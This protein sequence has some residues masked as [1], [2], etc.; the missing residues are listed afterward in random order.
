MTTASGAPALA[1]SPSAGDVGQLASLD[2]EAIGRNAVAA[3]LPTLRPYV[4][5]TPVVFLDREELGLAPGPL[6]LKL[7]HLQHSGSFKA[8]GAFA[9]LLTHRVP[10]AGIVAASG[11]NH[12]S[13]VAYAASRLQ[14][15]ATIF[16]PEVSSPAK[17]SRIESYGATLV[18]GG[19]DY[20]AARSA[21]ADF[22]ARTGAFDV[23][24]FDAVATILGAGSIALELQDQAPATATVLASVGGG[25]LLAGLCA[26]YAAQGAGANGTGGVRVVGVEPK[27][28]P[29]LT[30][31][32]GAGHPA[33]AP[34]GSIAIDSLAPR[35]LGAHTY[36]VIAR[37]GS[38]SVLVDDADISATQQ[39]LWDRLRLVV[40][41][42][43]C[44]SL[45]ALV[46]GCY[47]PAPNETVAVVLSGANTTAVDF[48]R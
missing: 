8:R 9:N 42:G 37:L 20:D 39:L 15:P 6:V 25:G 31:A 44:A 38:G 32:L 11:G 12:G 30:A 35:R 16:V 4:R 1:G 2:D 13:A 29:T 14:I 17:R 5:T 34:V 27:D 46:A 26:G 45:A 10:A 40:E 28:A 21:A 23:P 48:S 43:G 24:A 47:V 36:A 22:Q 7:E 3:L 18:V 41:P 19:P 33:D